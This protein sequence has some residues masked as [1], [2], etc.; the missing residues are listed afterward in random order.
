MMTPQVTGGNCEE[1]L[2]AAILRVR[3]LLAL[4]GRAN[5]DGHAEQESTVPAGSTAPSPLRE[6]TA[7]FYSNSLRTVDL[8]DGSSEK[9]EL[10]GH[11]MQEDTRHTHSEAVDRDE[12]EKSAVAQA[13]PLPRLR[14]QFPTLQ[15]RLDAVEKDRERRQKRADRAPKRGWFRSNPVAA[16][17]VVVCG[18]IDDANEDI[19]KKRVV[20][21]HERAVPQPLP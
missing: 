7:C 3:L 2:R 1:E 8:E 21:M 6:S 18:D 10:D 20:I 15:Q 9:V 14:W 12:R 11:K 13:L 19:K 4:H 16:A 5:T 17:A